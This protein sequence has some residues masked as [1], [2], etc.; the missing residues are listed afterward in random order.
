ME[1]KTKSTTKK[2]TKKVVKKPTSKKETKTKLKQ[3]KGFTLIELLAVI[4][5][6]GILMIIAIPSVTSYISNSRKSAYVDTAKEIAASTRNFVNEGK[7]EMYNT[8]I[9]YYIPAVC[10]ETENEAKSPYGDFE[11]AYVL[12]TYNGKGYNYYWMSRDEAGQGVKEPVAISDLNENDIESDIKA[13]SINTDYTKDN[14]SKVLILDSASCKEFK[15]GSPP[16]CKRATSLHT[17]PCSLTSGG[18]Y[19]AGYVDGSLGTTITYG[20]LVNGNV[21]AGDAFDCDVNGD[22]DYNSINERF[23]YITNYVKEGKNVAVLLYSNN[24][25]NGNINN[26]YASYYARVS[27]LQLIDSSITDSDNWHGPV[28]AYIDLP[29]TSQWSSNKILKPG[30]RQITNNNGTN[31]TNNGN[32]TIQMFDYGDKAARLPTYQEVI[33]ACGNTTP[34]QTGYLDNC[35]YLLDHIRSFENVTWVTGYWLE[36]P[37]ATS[38]ASGYVVNGRTRA[39]DTNSTKYATNGGGTR[40]VIETLMSN[41]E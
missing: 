34:N 9:T 22:G 29:S 35:S 23:Y 14:T 33:K 27:E 15:D 13:D 20:S 12:V 3:K 38:S 31:T 39:I 40:P 2:Q 19:S 17:S 7:L 26:S 37:L 32:N 25:G 16:L 10:I 18:C 41:L 21:K 24:V 11:E 36:T 6:L 5:I 4:I 8:D 1:K 30:V 28:T